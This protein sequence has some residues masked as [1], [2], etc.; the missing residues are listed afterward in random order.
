[1]KEARSSTSS[2][3]A[4]ETLVYHQRRPHRSTAKPGR[5]ISETVAAG[6]LVLA[7]NEAFAWFEAKNADSPWIARQGVSRVI[8]TKSVDAGYSAFHERLVTTYR[9]RLNPSGTPASAVMTVAR[10]SAGRVSV[11]V[12]KRFVYRDVGSHVRLDLPQELRAKL[13]ED[14]L[15]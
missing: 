5:C 4:I 10:K 3:G 1:M 8:L 13:D 11:S 2:R 6:V 7:D 9:I 15:S 12:M 14:R